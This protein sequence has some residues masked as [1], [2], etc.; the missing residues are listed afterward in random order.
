MLTIEAYKKAY[1]IT[2]TVD[3]F[4]PPLKYIPYIHYLVRFKKDQAKVQA[5]LGS[6]NEFNMMTIAYTAKLSLKV[7]PTDIG[8]QKIDCSTL[9]T[10]VIVLA[11][12]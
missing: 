6:N 4:I 5:L 3:S 10:F 7:Y 9:E 2:L 8:V 12:F 11:S 1:T